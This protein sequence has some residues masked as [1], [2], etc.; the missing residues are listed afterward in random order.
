M[1]LIGIL[2]SIL[3]IAAA[4]A[5]ALQKHPRSRRDSLNVTGDIEIP[6]YGNDLA[7]LDRQVEWLP[8]DN[9]QETCAYGEAK[10]VGEKV[11]LKSDCQKIVDYVS[12]REG[13][14][15]V[16]GYGRGDVYASLIN[17]GTCSFD[18]ARVDDQDLYFE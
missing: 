11:V 13:F 14:W 5:K 9:D 7:T 1:K 16:T 8:L 4:G 3:L 2:P 17:R 10:T 12:G 6:G 18:V 15:K